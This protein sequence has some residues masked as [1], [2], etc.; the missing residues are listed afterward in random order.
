MSKVTQTIDGVTITSV[1]LSGSRI[2]S[3]TL[4][5]KS[6]RLTVAY[7]N[8]VEVVDPADDWAWWDHLVAKYFA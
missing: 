4:N 6:S 2:L 3:M 7:A 1:T 8:D 5:H